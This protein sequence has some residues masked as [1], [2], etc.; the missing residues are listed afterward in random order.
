[1]PP[2]LAN[3]VAKLM[4]SVVSIASTGPMGDDSDQNS[5][6]DTTPDQTQPS[7]AAT[8]TSGTPADT[9]S[10]SVIPPPKAEEAL[11]SGFVIDPAGYIVTNNHVINGA[12]AVT[13]TFQDGTI[14][15]ATVIGTDKDG[16]LAVLKVNAGHKLAAV[17]F[18][19][20]SKLRVGDWVLAIGN[21][22]GLA[23]TT[24]AG[25][26]SAL[27]RN[28]GEDKFDDFIQTDAAVNRGNSGGPLFDISGHVIGVTSAIYSPS[29]GS[30][31]LGFA[32]PSAM[33]QPV[34]ASLEANGSVTRG[35]LGISTE[36]VT[37][38]IQQLL[39]LPGTQGALIGGT[40]PAGPAAG[41]LKP[42]DVLTSV[43][44]APITD[45]RSLLIRTAEIPAGQT[46]HAE[47][48]RDGTEQSADITV[49]A[50]P[51]NPIPGTVTP[52]AAA[53]INLT[54]IG[55]AVAA[56]SSQDGA[57]IL[58]VTAGGPAAK[59]GIVAADVVK[60]V[61]PD[62]VNSAADLKEALAKLSTAHQPTAALLIAGDT[63]NGDDPGPRWIAVVGQ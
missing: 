46:A 7:K 17:S 50:P 20:S 24:T 29:G 37:P 34:A 52:Q 16:D 11:G 55:M 58:S 53:N 4:P 18:G 62:P 35:W 57:Q 31:G 8:T 1:M 47:F 5:D 12:T 15:P 45:P 30:I 25:I 33:V 27:H 42:G 36:D 49:A 40:A 26:V 43:N 59:A 51:P 41:K 14:L 61:G 63:I 3:L 2:D 22:F 38:E 6:P 39:S 23:G 13:V 10:D 9:P 60:A 44:D 19:D 32:I 28:I 21:P 56:T 54:S 48:W